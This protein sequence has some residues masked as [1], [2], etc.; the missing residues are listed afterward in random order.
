MGS[1][2]RESL[3]RRLEVTLRFADLTRIFE[4]SD[5]VTTATAFFAETF[6]TGVLAFV[7]FCL[8]NPKS[9]VQVKKVFVPPLIGATVGAL[10]CVIAPLTQA[11]FNPARDFGPRIVA[12]LAGWKGVAFT[13]WW[14]YVL[15][16]VVGAPIGAA[17]AEKLLNNET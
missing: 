8:T 12:W 11:G 14:L 17:L 2:F 16:P 4:L 10:I 9:D 13:K 7:I 1:T 3:F 6:G 5:P 15:A